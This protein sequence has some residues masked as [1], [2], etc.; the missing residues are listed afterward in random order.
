MRRR[1]SVA[2]GVRMTTP[3]LTPNGFIRVTV[4]GADP[5]LKTKNGATLVRIDAI[6]AITEHA[7][8]STGIRLVDGTTLFVKSSLANLADEIGKS[9]RGYSVQPV[10]SSAPTR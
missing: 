9:D 6:A 3:F 10:A 1:G 2:Y 7:A 4:T 5:S 8:D